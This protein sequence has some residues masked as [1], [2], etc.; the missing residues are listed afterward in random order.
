MLV[1]VECK[2]A[3]HVIKTMDTGQ[4]VF[5]IDPPYIPD[6]RSNGVYAHELDN[7]DHERLVSQLLTVQGAVVLSGYEHP[8]YEP[9][10]ENGWELTRIQ[11]LSS[12]AVVKG[13]GNQLAKM[14]RVECV[15]R[16]PRCLQMLNQKGLFL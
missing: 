12:A 16:N 11:W 15:W 10:T 5:Y 6:T 14:G 2:S 8:I 13:D 3:D 9:L 1:Q 7:A 4:T